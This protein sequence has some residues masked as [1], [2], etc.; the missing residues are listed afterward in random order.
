MWVAS[1]QS[2]A[3]LIKLEKQGWVFYGFCMVH[4]ALGLMEFGPP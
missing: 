4:K 3:G 1:T 2:R